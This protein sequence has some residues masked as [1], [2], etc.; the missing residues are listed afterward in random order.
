MFWY[1][2]AS[3][4]DPGG[5][6][7]IW[8]NLRPSQNALLPPSTASD[9]VPILVRLVAVIFETVRG[10]VRVGAGADDGACTLYSQH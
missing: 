9:V 2:I 10:A 7:P 4:A 1:K 3:S 8:G 6:R 5:E